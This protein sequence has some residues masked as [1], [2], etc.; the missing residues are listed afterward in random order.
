MRKE[1]TF[2]YDYAGRRIEKKVVN[3]DTTATLSTKRFIYRGWDLVAEID[4]VSTGLVRSYVWGLDQHGRLSGANTPG[5]LLQI[6]YYSGGTPANSYLPTY[7]LSGNVTSLINASTG[8]LAAIYEYDPFGNPLRNETPDPTVADNPFRYATKWRDEETGLYYYGHRYYD[9]NHGRFINQDPIGET[10]GLNL[11]GFVGNNPVNLSDYLGWHSDQGGGGWRGEEDWG[12]IPVYPTPADLINRGA[13]DDAWWMAYMIARGNANLALYDVSTGGPGFDNVFDDLIGG[14]ENYI[15][16]LMNRDLQPPPEEQPPIVPPVIPP[17]VTP[18]PIDPPVTPPV[19]PPPTVPPVVAPVTPPQIS[20]TPVAV[21][22][23]SGATPSGPAGS[24]DKV[25]FVAPNSVATAEPPSY[26]GSINYA[27]TGVLLTYGRFEGQ[28]TNPANPKESFLI[29]GSLY[30]IG[31]QL[32]TISGTTDIVLRQDPNK[33]IGV[34]NGGFFTV[35]VSASALIVSFGSVSQT[36]FM[37]NG[38]QDTRPRVDFERPRIQIP[39]DTNMNDPKGLLS[40]KPSPGISI[41]FNGMVIEK[42]IPVVP[43]APKKGP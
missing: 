40:I 4:G 41:G 28:V 24:D 38:T 20:T 10:G 14:N 29:S 31:F 25:A 39:S 27:A 6:T 2:A 7:D 8:A 35:T 16:D 13:D 11:Y 15:T 34:A 21:V 36:V 42:V 1:L 5:S 37:N 32:G 19:T 3:L 33:L 23:A 30:G 26:E 17:P 18:P 12:D 43:E 22:V 9:A